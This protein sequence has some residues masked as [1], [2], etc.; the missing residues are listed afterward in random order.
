MPSEFGQDYLQ[1]LFCI[2]LSPYGQSAVAGSSPATSSKKGPGFFRNRGLFTV[3]FPW[4]KCGAGCGADRRPRPGRRVYPPGEASSSHA[5]S[6]ARGKDELVDGKK[7]HHADAAGH[8]GGDD[9]VDKGGYDVLGHP[10]PDAV[11]SVE[12]QVHHHHAQGVDGDLLAQGAVVIEGE[13]PLQGEVDA[14]AK[15]DG[16]PDRDAVGQS[17]VRNRVADHIEG[18]GHAQQGELGVGPAPAVLRQRPEQPRQKQ[19]DEVLEEGHQHTDEEEKASLPEPF[20][21]LGVLAREALPE[22]FHTF[23]SFAPARAAA[24]AFSAFL[25]RSHAVARAPMPRKKRPLKS[26]SS[27][28]VMAIS[29]APAVI[30]AMARMGIL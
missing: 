26:S 29:T 12:G 5:F 27:A 14:L 6:E 2:Y 18:K 17:A 20:G 28:L 23:P 10:H 8:H 21:G 13:S 7:D 30:F 3:F 9:V 16:D 19:H 25:L 24:A 1:S 4:T 22:L 11:E 15:H